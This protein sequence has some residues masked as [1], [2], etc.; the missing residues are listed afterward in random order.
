MR[1]A[2][3]VVEQIGDE[4]R[5]DRL[6]AGGLFLLLGVG[7]IGD[8]G[9]DACGRCPSQG[10]DDEQQLHQVMVDRIAHRLDDEDVRAAH[11]LL[12]LDSGLAVPPRPDDGPPER[13]LQLPIIVF[14]EPGMGRPAKTCSRPST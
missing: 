10:V 3:A 1:S 9:G 6:A 8:D 2:P 5:R 11:V 4:L 14:G 12:E 13:R 7:V